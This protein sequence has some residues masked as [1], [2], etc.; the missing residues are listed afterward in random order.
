MQSIK[1]IDTY[2]Y[3]ATTGRIKNRKQNK[4][5][6]LAF[7]GLISGS[8]LEALSIWYS[9]AWSPLQCQLPLEKPQRLSMSI[10]YCLQGFDNALKCIFNRETWA[11]NSIHW[12]FATVFMV[13]NAWNLPSKEFQRL[14]F[15]EFFYAANIFS[16]LT[17]N[18]S[19]R[20]DPML[21]FWVKSLT[22]FVDSFNHHSITYDA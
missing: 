20:G 10:A 13:D 14:S 17:L 12:I 19:V 2:T 18:G 22:F 4:D 7:G 5:N 1:S 21:S 3:I 9:D 6:E 16:K 8:C 15:Q 11:Q